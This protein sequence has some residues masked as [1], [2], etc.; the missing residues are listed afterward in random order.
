[1]YVLKLSIFLYAH[2]GKDRF[3]QKNN[4]RTFVQWISAQVDAAMK[5]AFW[6]FIVMAA[7]SFVMPQE[8][9]LEVQ[10]TL[11]KKDSTLCNGQIDAKNNTWRTSGIMSGSFIAIVFRILAIP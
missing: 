2:N 10:V 5:P 3:D 9:G 8:V 6:F 7:N 11:T 1:M 4:P